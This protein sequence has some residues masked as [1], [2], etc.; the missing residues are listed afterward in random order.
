MGGCSVALFLGMNVAQ[1]EQVLEWCLLEQDEQSDE[2]KGEFT[3][4]RGSL[5]N[6]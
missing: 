4:G 6:N 5:L 1:C 2:S 3:G